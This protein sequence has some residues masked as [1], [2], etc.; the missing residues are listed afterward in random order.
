MRSAV[1]AAARRA[2]K[3][4][5]DCPPPREG[6]PLCSCCWHAEFVGGGRT[7]GKADI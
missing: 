5:S 6:E 7:R 4:G 3:S 2:S 1:E